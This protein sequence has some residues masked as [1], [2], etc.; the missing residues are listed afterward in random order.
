M[1]LLYI[2][3]ILIP[4]AVIPAIFLLVKIYRADRREKEPPQLL[5]SLVFCGILATAIAMV[6]ERVG[7]W[8]LGCV[9]PENS[10]FFRRIE[11]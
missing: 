5:T 10:R 7:F 4:A 9:L 1:V 6:A 3:R 11:G 2:H 8:L